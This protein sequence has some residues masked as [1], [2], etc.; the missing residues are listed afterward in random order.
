VNVAQ[1]LAST[2]AKARKASSAKERS[3]TSPA[4]DRAPY[5]REAQYPSP[6]TGKFAYCA[7]RTIDTF[8]IDND[9][10]AWYL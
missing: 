2:P 1:H 4:S 6:P 3:W 9:S 7:L 8:S 10:L 5:A